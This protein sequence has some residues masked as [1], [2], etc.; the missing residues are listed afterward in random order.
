[1]SVLFSGKDPARENGVMTNG[2]TAQQ[3]GDKVVEKVKT[4]GTSG[5]GLDALLF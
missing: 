2:V 5:E 1:M 4:E 3:N